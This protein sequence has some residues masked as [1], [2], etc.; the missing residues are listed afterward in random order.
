[1]DG[2]YKITNN[3]RVEV[4][5]RMK[6]VVVKIAM[7]PIYCYDGLL[8]RLTFSVR[9]HYKINHFGLEVMKSVTEKRWKWNLII[10]S[11]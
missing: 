2:K 9:K 6:C 4:L 11:L 3:V 10:H 1:M 5:A 8:G 7:G